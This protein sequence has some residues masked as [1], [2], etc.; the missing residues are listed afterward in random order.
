VAAFSRYFFPLREPSVFPC[1][2]DEAE[3]R[4]FLPEWK[5]VAYWWEWLM[6]R[7]DKRGKCSRGPQVLNLITIGCFADDPRSSLVHVLARLT[8]LVGPA[9]M[10]RERH[11]HRRFF[12]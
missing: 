9:Q 6:K 8:S 5:A 1:T 7:K 11:A 2:V 12:V 3:G 10:I 4:F